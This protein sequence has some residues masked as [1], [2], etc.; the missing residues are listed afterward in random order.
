MDELPEPWRTAAERAG[1]RQ[2][3]RGLGEAAGLSHVTIGRLIR[4]RR[5]SARTV[6]AVAEALKVGEAEVYEWA[7]LEVSELGPWVPPT[8]AHK[9]NP[10]ARAALSELIL[11]IT[12][13]G[14]TDAGTAEAGK[15]TGKPG[16]GRVVQ[17]DFG[18]DVLAQRA[19]RKGASVGRMMA[20]ESD[21][22]W[23]GSQDDGSMEPS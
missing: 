21:G 5:T 15:K 12:Q 11:A 14:G 22:R 8:E 9:L 6:R 3:L 18:G 7:R 23:E 1:V 2:T 10:R 16:R 20:E 4:E 13:E 17:G 19:A